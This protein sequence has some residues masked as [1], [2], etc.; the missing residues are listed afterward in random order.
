MPYEG[1]SVCTLE[2]RTSPGDTP[3]E[4]GGAHVGTT[5]DEKRGKMFKVVPV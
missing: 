2:Q 1:Q 4:K 5:F 3:G